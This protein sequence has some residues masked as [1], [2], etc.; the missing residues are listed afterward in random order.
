M[1]SGSV[2]PGSKYYP[3]FERLK[4]CSPEKV[5]FSFEEIETIMGQALPASA[6]KQRAWWSNRDSD[7]A[8]QA[9]AWIAAGYHVKSIDL[10]QAI[11]TFH[12]FQAHYTVQREAGSGS[13]IWNNIAI[14]ALRKSMGLT[15]A[16]FAQELGVRRQTVSEWETG[17]YEPDRSTAKHLERI[18]EQEQFRS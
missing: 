18:A 6:H 5:S 9:K 11:V 16:K 13:I 4:Q 2:K 15:Q 12:P 1:T 8:L 10:T 3:L 7:R 17:I 14:K